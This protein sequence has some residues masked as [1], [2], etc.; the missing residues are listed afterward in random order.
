[1]ATEAMELHRLDQ[2]GQTEF[3]ARPT[4]RY[5]LGRGIGLQYR[6]R[7]RGKWIRRRP[8][9][10][11]ILP[12][13]STG[14]LPVA[15]AG[16]RHRPPVQ[17]G[18]GRSGPRRPV[19]VHDP[20]RGRLVVDHLDQRPGQPGRRE[21]GR[22]DDLQHALRPGRSDHLQHP[23]PGRRV[24]AG[25][26]RLFVHDDRDGDLRLGDV[27][28]I[29]HHNRPGPGQRRQRRQRP[30]RGRV[31]C[32]WVAA[33]RAGQLRG[34]RPVHRR[35]AGDRAVRPGLRQRPVV[36]PG[37]GAGHRHVGIADPGK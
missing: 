24:R 25:H 34:P 18:A 23:A 20:A 31:E 15:R 6:W 22:R 37:P 7:R 1:M 21:P 4:S 11:R 12:R 13:S 8:R 30:I 16:H 36:Y 33:A 17:L 28:G 3:D 2:P 29:A 35:P 32:R 5:R 19:P 14:D 26:R 27:G 9:H 10:R